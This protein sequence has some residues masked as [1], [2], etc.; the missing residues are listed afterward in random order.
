MMRKLI[1]L[2]HGE[3]A[4]KQPGQ[5]DFDRTL[6]KR[7]ATSIV[8]LAKVLTRE[9]LVPDY[10]LVSPATRTKQTVDIVI[11]QLALAI[12]PHFES[13]L[14]NKEAN[15]YLQHISH[16][17]PNWNCLLVIGHNPSISAMAGKLSNKSFVGL[18]PGEAAILEFELELTKA[19]LVKTVGP[20]G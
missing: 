18:H 10:L 8:A 15:V 16:I 19:T 2:R 12:A 5:S 7:G 6:T 13:D 1:L 20:F 14:Y 4:D 3:S 9:N 11:D 17:Q